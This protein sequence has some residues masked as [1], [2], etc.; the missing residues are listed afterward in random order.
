M[1]LLGAYISNLDRRGKL[2]VLDHLV[3]VVVVVV[4]G[5]PID[6]LWEDDSRGKLMI[7][8]HLRWGY[9]PHNILWR[10][11]APPGWCFI[12]S[13]NIWRSVIPSGKN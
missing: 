8:D 13:V 2:R 10:H 4:V 9:R 12:I 3:V 1:F 5:L 6:L 7:L 11:G